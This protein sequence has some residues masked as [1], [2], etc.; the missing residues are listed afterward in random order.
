MIKFFVNNYEGEPK[1][2]TNKHGKKIISTYKYQFVGQNASG[3]DNYIVLNSLP[4]S[5]AT[6]KIIKTS[7][8][9]IKLSFRAGFANEGDR[10]VPKYAKFVR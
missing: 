8:G 6:V 4:K 7:R 3:F 2:I 5:S 1:I 9:F 10:E